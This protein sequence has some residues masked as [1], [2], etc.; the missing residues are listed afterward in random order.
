MNAQFAYAR[1]FSGKDVKV[2]SV[3]SG[4]RLN[5]VKFVNREPVAITISGT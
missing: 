1:G 2:G 5:H 3:D 4:L